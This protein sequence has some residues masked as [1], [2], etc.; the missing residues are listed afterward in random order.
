MTS[1][2]LGLLLLSILTVAFFVGA[3]IVAYLGDRESAKLAEK[4]RNR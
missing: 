1:N 3:P 4:Y 2:E